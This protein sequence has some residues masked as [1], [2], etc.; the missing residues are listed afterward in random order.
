M[1]IEYFVKKVG[2]ALLS[3]YRFPERLRLSVERASVTID[4]RD[5]ADKC[6]VL[7]SEADVARLMEEREKK[8]KDHRLCRRLRRRAKR[9]PLREPWWEGIAR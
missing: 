9:F 1:S 5:G 8:A 3:G 7:K 6:H 2:G 4:F